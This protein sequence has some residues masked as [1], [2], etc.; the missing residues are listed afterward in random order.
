[1]SHDKQRKSDAKLTVAFLRLFLDGTKL[2]DGA[3]TYRDDVLKTGETAEH[4]LLEFLEQRGIRARGTQSVLKQVRALR[5]LSA[6]DGL[7]ARHKRL[8]S[9]GAFVDPAPA[10]T[11]DVL[12]YA[13]PRT[14][15]P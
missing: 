10:H 15:S 14:H 6:L 9:T 1:M 4:G 8:L 5:K 3:E 13:G 12:E 11:H 2:D 7:I